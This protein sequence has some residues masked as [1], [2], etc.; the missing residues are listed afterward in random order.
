MLFRSNKLL[1][2]GIDLDENLNQQAA[3]GLTLKISTAQSRVEVWV[4]PTDEGI[5]TAQEA[6]KLLHL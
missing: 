1:W 4:V 2:L 6:L 5:M 3:E